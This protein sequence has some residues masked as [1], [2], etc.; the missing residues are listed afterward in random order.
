MQ[1]VSTKLQEEITKLGKRRHRYFKSLTTS[2]LLS[3]IAA[4]ARAADQLLVDITS[5]FAPAMAITNLQDDIQDMRDSVP[6]ADFQECFQSS[7]YV[8]TNQSYVL[9][10]YGST[11]DVCPQDGVEL[12]VEP[13]L[14]RAVL[15]D[16]WSRTIEV[17]EWYWQI[18]CL[19][20]IEN[21]PGTLP[22]LGRWNLLHA[23]W[24]GSGGGRYQ[25][26]IYGIMH[27]SGA[28]HTV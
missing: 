25:K 5:C 14:K 20:W 10:N 18:L 1:K 13:E 11:F 26:D 6:P 12:P 24:G 28:K 2:N 7:F 16:E 22:S 9:L 17:N 4:A 15:Q 23:F 8:T 27:A 21:R 19:A 3:E